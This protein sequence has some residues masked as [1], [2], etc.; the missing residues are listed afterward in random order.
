MGP[1]KTSANMSMFVVFKEIEK[2][3]QTLKLCC[4]TDTDLFAH[5]PLRLS[6]G[7]NSDSA[8]RFDS[9]PPLLSAVLDTRSMC[10]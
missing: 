10:S 7:F 3:A 8:L 5:S 4:N 2:V 1:Q 9:D 6:F